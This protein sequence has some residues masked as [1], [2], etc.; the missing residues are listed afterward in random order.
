M[1]I[2]D[3][4]CH[5]FELNRAATSRCDRCDKNGNKL[6]YKCI[7]H[8]KLI[9]E[10]CIEEGKADV[11]HSILLNIGHHE[12]PQP[13]LQEPRKLV[14]KRKASKGPIAAAQGSPKP[15]KQGRK[16]YLN[17]VQDEEDKNQNVF[18]AEA[19]SAGLRGKQTARSPQLT[20]SQPIS[21]RTRTSS[22]QLWPGLDE[23][24][25]YGRPQ[26]IVSQEAVDGLTERSS[27]KVRDVEQDVPSTSSHG[28][29]NTSEERPASVGTDKMGLEFLLRAAEIMDVDDRMALKGKKSPDTLRTGGSK[30]GSTINHND[31][32]T[33]GVPEEP[34]PRRGIRDL[35]DLS[36]KG[37]L[38]VTSNMIE[39]MS[40]STIDHSGAHSRSTLKFSE[41]QRHNNTKQ[42]TQDHGGQDLYTPALISFRQ[43]Q[44]ETS[45]AYVRPSYATNETRSP[46]RFLHESPKSG[47]MPP[48]LPSASDSIYATHR[49]TL[50]PYRSE[51]DPT[52]SN[53][54]LAPLTSTPYHQLSETQNYDAQPRSSAF[55]PINAG[56]PRSLTELAQ[57]IIN[58]PLSQTRTMTGPTAR[59]YLVVNT[60][61]VQTLEIEEGRSPGSVLS[62]IPTGAITAFEAKVQ[63][64]EDQVMESQHGSYT[65]SE[66][67]QST[68]TP[69]VA[70][71]LKVLHRRA[72]IVKKEGGVYSGSEM[73]M[74]K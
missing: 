42:H 19:S 16:R 33:Q 64:M 3:Y 38:S 34:G 22:A 30:T 47:V 63:E 58:N 56:Q 74:K 53:V 8:L 73:R 9:C 14:K 55:T 70:K 68:E 25:P 27:S 52:R 48:H 61:P 17:I 29:G 60:G 39:P 35:R 44:Q 50:E 37:S 4:E 67:P 71:R 36:S 69:G 2:A 5:A 10:K 20:L 6:L 43:L 21:S 11:R 12:L 40:G 57:Y 31:A 54:R 46:A 49:P 51:C 66:S 62:P 23:T 7:K 18:A 28:F 72:T 1:N 65:R 41:L 59:P 26:T 24:V 32:Q 13:T 45:Q 15:P